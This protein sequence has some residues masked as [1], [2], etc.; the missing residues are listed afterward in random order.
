METVLVGGFR[1]VG[2]EGIQWCVCQIAGNIARENVGK[3]LRP[4]VSIQSLASNNIGLSVQ[5]D[6][7]ECDVQS[8]LLEARKVL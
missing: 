6:M 1:E 4:S 3:H 7:Y 8:R 2:V 5:R